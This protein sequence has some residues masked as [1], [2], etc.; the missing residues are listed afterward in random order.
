M[1]IIIICTKTIMNLLLSDNHD[2]VDFS[3]IRIQFS[4]LLEKKKT[5]FAY[6]TL[7]FYV[8]YVCLVDI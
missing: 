1:K 4:F 7:A 5:L 2:T 3:M 8:I 6:V